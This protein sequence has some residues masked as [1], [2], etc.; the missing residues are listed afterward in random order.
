MSAFTLAL[1]GGFVALSISVG[2][3]NGRGHGLGLDQTFEFGRCSIL[4][5]GL[6][7]LF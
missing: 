6:V 4:K 5:K 1:A 3:H 2:F 7:F